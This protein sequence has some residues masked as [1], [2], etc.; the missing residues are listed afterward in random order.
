MDEYIIQLEVMMVDQPRRPHP[1]AF[2]WN[3]GMVQHVLKSDLDLRELE[4][5][6]VNSPGLAF[7][8]YD[9]HGHCSLT[10]EAALAICLHLADTFAEWIGRSTHLNVVPL[11]LEGCQCMMASQERCRQ[12][13]WTQEQPSLPIHVTGSASSSSSQ[14]VGGVPPIPEAQDGAAEKKHLGLVWVGCTGTQLR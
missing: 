3:G 2:S 11:L 8:F 10:K 14:L 12:H 1:P 13:I 6:Q 4:H 7:L 9:R 5:V